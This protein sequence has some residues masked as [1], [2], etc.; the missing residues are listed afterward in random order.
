MSEDLKRVFPTPVGMNRLTTAV[1]IAMLR[2]P[3]AC[4]DEPQAKAAKNGL[5]AVFPTPVGMNRIPPPGVP[6]SV[7]CSPRLWG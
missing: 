6:Q 7:T 1:L 3:H 4:G 2:V 5:W